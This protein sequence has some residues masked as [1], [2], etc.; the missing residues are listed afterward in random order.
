M[1]GLVYQETVSFSILDK[2]E[3]IRECGGILDE[4]FIQKGMRANMREIKFD[5]TISAGKKRGAFIATTA[6]TPIYKD[7]D[8]TSI[9]P[10][11][12]HSL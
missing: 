8:A 5:E 7:F 11:A 2:N 9:S 4:V 3:K 10:E 12:H 6:W 1:I